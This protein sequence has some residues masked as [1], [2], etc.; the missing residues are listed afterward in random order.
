L[1]PLTR[2]LCE[3]GHRVYFALRDVRHASVVFADTPITILPAPFKIGLPDTA[4]DPP[5]TFAHILHNVGFAHASELLSMVQAWRGMYDLVRPDLLVFDHSPTAMLA[6][7]GMDV[8]R[9]QIALGFFWPPDETPLRDLRPWLPRDQAQLD[10]D[11]AHVL[12]VMNEVLD[13]WAAPRLERVSQLY[14]EIDESALLTFPELDHFGPRPDVRYWGTWDSS[15]G[16]P[17]QWPEAAGPRIFA[18]L[19][20]FAALPA[21][22]QELQRRALPTLVYAPEITSA[23]RA[24]FQSATMH[25]ADRP[26]DLRA[27]RS[28]CQYAVMHGTHGVA[29]ELALGGVPALHF[30]LTLEQLI[31]TQKMEACGLGVPAD[32]N[33]SAAI[34]KKLDELLTAPRYLAGAR[35]FAQRYAFLD[36]AAQARNLAARLNSLLEA[37]SKVV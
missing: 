20:P 1:Q 37:R 35:A 33:D 30:P 18:Y 31:L 5:R 21:L 3:M 16:Q 6:S 11:E 23:L 36:A 9:A 29:V 13:H 7:R 27:V 19:K 12:A 8:L 25:V 28:S 15:W 24:R 10:R 17:P 4:I 14:A 2:A 22:L 26:L 34:P 32:A